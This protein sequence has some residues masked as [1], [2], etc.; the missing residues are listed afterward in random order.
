MTRGVS[1]KTSRG[2]KPANND[3]A[4]ETYLLGA[5]ERRIQHKM[6]ISNLPEIS[7]HTQPDH[8]QRKDDSGGHPMKKRASVG[9]FMSFGAKTDPE[10]SDQTG[11]FQVANLYVLTRFQR[12]PSGVKDETETPRLPTMRPKTLVLDKSLLKADSATIGGHDG[13]KD[14]ARFKKVR[15]ATMP[16]AKAPPEE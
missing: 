7:D 6:L 16:F 9:T 14:E 3:D 1:R 10:G 11:S 4:P 13:H 15:Q 2:H 12:M 5:P 8:K